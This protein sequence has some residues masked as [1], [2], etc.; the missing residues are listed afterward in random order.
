MAIRKKDYLTEMEKINSNDKL[1]DSDK[2]FAKLAY[3]E[4]TIFSLIKDEETPSKP[5]NM[6]TYIIG[7]LYNM[8]EAWV[9]CAPVKIDATDVGAAMM[10]LEKLKESSKQPIAEITFIYSE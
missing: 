5:D 7:L 1:S 9:M 3:Q 2:M 6:K 8:G 4:H 10:E